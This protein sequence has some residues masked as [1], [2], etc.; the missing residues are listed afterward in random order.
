MVVMERKTNC[1]LYICTPF[2]S[3]NYAQELFYF[4]DLWL[5]FG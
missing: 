4:L 5:P 2:C 1:I 3:F